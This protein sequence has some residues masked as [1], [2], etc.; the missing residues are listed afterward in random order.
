M[1]D[2]IPYRGTPH[3]IQALLCSGNQP[4]ALVR[5]GGGVYS[6]GS[7]LPLGPACMSSAGTRSTTLT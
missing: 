5:I 7:T 3:P 4:A 6:C 2:Q 1:I